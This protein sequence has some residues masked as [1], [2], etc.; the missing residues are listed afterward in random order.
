MDRRLARPIMGMELVCV[1]GRGERAGG[2]EGQVESVYMPG[3]SGF[4]YL[5]EADPTWVSGVHYD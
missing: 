4:G 2:G 3:A 5:N 1:W